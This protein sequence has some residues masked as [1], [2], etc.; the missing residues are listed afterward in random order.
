V[1]GLLLIIQVPDPSDKRVMAPGSRL[2]DRFSLRLERAEHMVR[3][4][5]DDIIVDPAPLRPTL[6]P[7]FNVVDP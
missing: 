7:R 4:V 6:G 5:F 2:I 3:M 1:I